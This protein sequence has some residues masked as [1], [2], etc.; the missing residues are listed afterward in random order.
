MLAV[1]AM[2]PLLLSPGSGDPAVAQGVIQPGVS[3]VNETGGQCTTNWV[4]DGS[5]AHA[6]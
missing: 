2:L 6:G 4:Y 3:I 5:G 1:V